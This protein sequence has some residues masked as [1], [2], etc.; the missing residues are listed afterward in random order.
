MQ[1]KNILNSIKNFNEKIKVKSLD[2]SSILKN[3]WITNGANHI[4]KANGIVY[5]NIAVRNGTNE[6]I[7]TLPERI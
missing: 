2:V 1:V 6:L 5:I 7:A 3:G 4:F